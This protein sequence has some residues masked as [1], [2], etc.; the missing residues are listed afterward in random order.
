MKPFSSQELERFNRIKEICLGTV[1]RLDNSKQLNYKRYESLFKMFENN[2]DA[3]RNWDVLND[4]SLDSTLQIFALP[5]E[6]TRMTQIKNAAD[7][8][9]VPLEEYI[10]YRF[11][12]NDPIRSKVEVPVG[13]V[14]IKRVRVKRSFIIDFYIITANKYYDLEKNSRHAF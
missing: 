12:P 1:K 2:P 3:F 14:H 9:N 5:F 13:Y 8:L 6:E 10:Y 4:E 11:D 7:Y